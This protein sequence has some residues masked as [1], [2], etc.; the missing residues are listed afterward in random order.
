[1]WLGN[2][3]INQIGKLYTYIRIDIVSQLW[4]ISLIIK[5]FIKNYNKEIIIL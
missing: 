4:L 1:M 3:K 5:I 2:L